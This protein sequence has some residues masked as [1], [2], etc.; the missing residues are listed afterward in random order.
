MALQ[1]GTLS[2]GTAG[3]VIVASLTWTFPLSSPWV[4]GA[5][6]MSL[7]FLLCSLIVFTVKIAQV[8]GRQ[9]TDERTAIH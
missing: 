7:S 8:T 4:H 5:A 1:V 2:F 3:L 6:W 9:P